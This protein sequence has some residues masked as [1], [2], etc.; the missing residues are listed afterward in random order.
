MARLSSTTGTGSDALLRK[1]L[2][3]QHV[4]LRLVSGEET[5]AGWIVGFDKT[6][7]FFT[8][9]L[10][11]DTVAYMRQAL[12]RITRPGGVKAPSPD[13]AP[14]GFADLAQYVEFMRHSVGAVQCVPLGRRKAARF[15][16]LIDHLEG[17]VLWFRGINQDVRQP[18]E[19]WV[20]LSGLASIGRAYPD[21][22]V[23]DAAADLSTDRKQING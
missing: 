2:G 14:E 21:E 17:D 19:Q 16:G 5:G 4:S 20:L 6:A 12:V 23:P 3:K 13:P 15:V 9:N 7:V 22:F 1:L 11:E 18:V 8:R 10:P